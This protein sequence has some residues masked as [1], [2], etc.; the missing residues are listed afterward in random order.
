MACQTQWR[1]ASMGG[2]TG[3]DYPSVAMVMD[4][5]A[6]KGEERRAAFDGVRVLEQVALEEMN[7]GKP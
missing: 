5:R 4:E 7:K 6:L 3:L 2:P 1:V